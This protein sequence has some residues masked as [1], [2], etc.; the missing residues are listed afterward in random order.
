MEV[1][2]YYANTSKD[3]KINKLLKGMGKFKEKPK[4]E[5]T[6][7]VKQLMSYYDIYFYSRKNRPSKEEKNKISQLDINDEI[8]ISN[9][10]DEKLYFTAID[11]KISTENNKKFINKK[12]KNSSS[13]QND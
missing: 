10:D 8:N 6:K 1:I 5:Y 7:R 3:K 2:K 4:D 12:R 9:L 11:Y 13:S